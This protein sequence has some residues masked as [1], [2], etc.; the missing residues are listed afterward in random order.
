MKTIGSLKKKESKIKASLTQATEHECPKCGSPMVI[1]WGRNGR[2][3]ACSAYPKCKTTRPLPEEEA[4]TRTKEKCDKCGSPMV[5]KTG[6][7][8]RFMACSDYPT[9][10]NTK[11][12]TLG[13]TCP[14]PGC[15]GNLVVRRDRRGR[16]FYGCSNY[17]T[18]DFVTRDQPVKTACPMCEHPFMLLKSSKTKGEYLECPQC[19]HQMSPEPVE[20]TTPA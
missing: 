12:I 10:K 4:K 6:R 2:V 15:G 7:F 17:P 14:K 3:L 8:G 19:R 5:I 9:C 11:P 20:S 16:T 1:K 13:I 18:C